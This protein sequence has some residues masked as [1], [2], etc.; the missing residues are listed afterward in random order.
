MRAV[1]AV[2]PGGARGE[3]GLLRRPGTVW[4]AG[5]RGKSLRAAGAWGEPGVL[6]G[7]GAVRGTGA[8]GENRVSERNKHL[9]GSGRPRGKS[10]SPRERVL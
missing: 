1:G 7:T 5:V 8:R 6:R 2:R 4:G 10:Y 3:L 9:E